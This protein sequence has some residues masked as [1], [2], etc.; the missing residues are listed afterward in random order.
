MELATRSKGPLSVFSYNHKH[1]KR[2]KASRVASLS[3]KV[4][5]F[6]LLDVLRSEECGRRVRE[7]QPARRSLALIFSAP[8]THSPT[9]SE[10]AARMH[11]AV[12]L[13]RRP[14]WKTAFFLPLFSGKST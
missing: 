12:L 11:L 7:R 4:V 14:C 13:P 8:Q 6:L 3:D 5:A 2:T 9:E 1:R 10:I